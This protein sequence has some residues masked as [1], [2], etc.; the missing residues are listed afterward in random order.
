MERIEELKPM[1]LIFY[2]AIES[3]NTDKA[4]F[5]FTKKNFADKFISEDK[6]DG[7]KS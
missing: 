2:R 4:S 5:K 6:S 3:M 1:L 7:S